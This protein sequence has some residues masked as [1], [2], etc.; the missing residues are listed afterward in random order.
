[1]Q[2]TRL[3]Y[4]YSSPTRLEGVRFTQPGLNDFFPEEDELY[5]AAVHDAEVCGWFPNSTRKVNYRRNKIRGFGF[6]IGN[7]RRDDRVAYLF[8]CLEPVPELAEWLEGSPS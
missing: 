6:T 5:W 4:L 1:M 8:A 2:K 3:F 7:P